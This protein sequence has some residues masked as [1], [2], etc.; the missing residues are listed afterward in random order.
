MLKFKHD[1]NVLQ[2]FHDNGVYCGDILCKEDGF[3][4]WWPEYPSKGGC[5]PAYFLHEVAKKLDELNAPQE[6]AI[7]DYFN[8]NPV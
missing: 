6:K 3:Y 7:E 4:D 1:G 2:I 5:Y 8:A